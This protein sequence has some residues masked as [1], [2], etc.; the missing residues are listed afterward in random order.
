MPISKIPGGPSITWASSTLRMASEV[1]VLVTRMNSVAVVPGCTAW[2]A[3]V[4]A[5]SARLEG[6]AV[7]D[8]MDGS[9]RPAWPGEL[10][11][12]ARVERAEAVVRRALRLVSLVPGQ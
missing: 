12:Y 1:L 8:T 7:D 4:D 3:V 11:G 6:A 9:R 5:A 2:M 10:P